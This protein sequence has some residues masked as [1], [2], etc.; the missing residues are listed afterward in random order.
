[1]V[2]KTPLAGDLIVGSGGCRKVRVAGRGKGKSGGYR[3]I[4]FHVPAVGVSLLWVLSKGQASNLTKAQVNGL[5]KVAKAI[6]DGRQAAELTTTIIP[7][8]EVTEMNN[9]DFEGLMEGLGE[10]LAH[11]RGEDVPGLVVHIPAEIDT[12]AMRKALGGLTQAEFARRFGFSAAAVRDWEQGRRAPDQSTRAYLK[13]IRVDAGAV[14]RA[15]EAEL[16]PA[17]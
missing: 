9:K 11:V 8:T 3:L 12:K 2:S 1:M 14:T 6:E 15:L 7:E 4:T 17:G 5:A 16:V 13:V 10:V